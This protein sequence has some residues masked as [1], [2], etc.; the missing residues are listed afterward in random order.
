MDIWYDYEKNIIYIYIYILLSGGNQM[1]CLTAD[2][3]HTASFND[4]VHNKVLFAWLFLK[5]FQSVE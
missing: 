1:K 2:M 4:N 3:A 5:V